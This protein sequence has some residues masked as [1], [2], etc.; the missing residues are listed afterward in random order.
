MSR[1]FLH[2]DRLTI[3]RMPGIAPGFTIDA[4]DG[5][6]LVIGPNES[7]K[8]SLVRAFRL[9]LWPNESAPT[10]FGADAVF[11]DGDGP[12]RAVRQGRSAEPWSRDGAVVAPPSLPPGHLAACYRLGLLDLHR[13]QPGEVEK[14]LAAAIRR[15][16]AGGF[17]IDPVRDLFADEAHRLKLGRGKYQEAAEQLR[18]LE[19][20]Q[21]AL[22]AEE[23]GL[24]K[25]EIARDAAEAALR[26]QR[27]LEAALAWRGLDRR[28]QALQARLAE[29]P[30]GMER[31][32][33]DDDT[34]LAKVDASI[35]RLTEGVAALEERIAARLRLIADLRLAGD[36][37][38][39][40]EL[41]AAATAASQEQARA[42]A[43]VAEATAAVQ[44]ARTGL[45]PE[46][47]AG[48][49]D[50]ADAEAVRQLVRRH[51]DLTARLA[52]VAGWDAAL[53]AFT[54]T[55]TSATGLREETADTAGRSRGI[56]TA[57]APWLG[58]A[59]LVAG[60]ALAA[61]DRIN[62]GL[63]AGAVGVLLSILGAITWRRQAAAARQLGAAEG[64][65]DARQALAE[66][67]TLRRDEAERQAGQ[68][69]AARRELLTRHGRDPERDD[70]DL[71]H[72][73]D[74][75]IRWRAAAAE[76]AVAE[77]RRDHDSA[78]AT[79]ACR[80]AAARLAE[81]GEPAE[82]NLA[83]VTAGGIRVQERQRRCGELEA[84][85]VEDRTQQKNLAVESAA[86]REARRTL[87]VRLGLDA[88]ADTPDEV[89]TEVDRRVATLAQWQEL[90][91]ERDEVQAEHQ[92][93]FASLDTGEDRALLN[94]EDERLESAIAAGREQ[95]AQ[96]DELL[97]AI[98]ALRERIRSARG[99]RDLEDAQAAL[100]SQADRIGELFDSHR[101]GLAGHLLLD[102]IAA[103]YEE[104]TRPPV[105]EELNR[106]LAAFTG[107]R[108]HL[109]VE[110]TAA[111][112]GFVAIGDDGD[113]RDLTRL[114]DG[115]RAQLLLAARLAFLNRS[116]DGTGLPLF[117]DE[118]LTAS[119]PE[120]FGA[121]AVALGT[122]A[123]D[124]GR[125]VFYLTSNPGDVGAWRTALDA[126]GLPPAHVIDLAAVRALGGAA[127]AAQLAPAAGA[128][129]PSPEGL[130]GPAYA[131]LLLVPALDPRRESDG[132]HM[133]Y[134]CREDTTLLHRLLCAGVR[135]LG[136]WRRSGAGLTAA[137]HFTPA[138]SAALANRAAVADAFL[139]SWRIGRGAPLTPEDLDAS[140]A[141]SDVFRGPARELLD[142]TGPNAAA[143]LAR[144]QDGALPRFS[145][146]KKEALQDYLERCGHLD[147]RAVLT[148]EELVAQV[149][150]VSSSALSAADVRRLVLDLVA[151]TAR[152]DG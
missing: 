82:P 75:V 42:D 73:W 79:A 45:D 29:L 107:N 12:L 129:I 142:Q 62:L 126:A 147:D 89:Q 25:L 135:T 145:A 18:S 26:A 52:A 120:R 17:D 124:T 118:A 94:W 132:M 144:V 87:L 11:H 104:D 53:G 35:T 146:S 13:A 143:F 114:S 96:R 47:A 108:Y 48:P 21:E 92:R 130:D 141:F 68:A 84:A 88:G 7:G 2:L 28:L 117:L 71:A 57:A 16:M 91:G 32:R 133:Y 85:L 66:L 140:E 65:R 127:T 55:A 4:R 61:T 81:L 148:P 115:T 1:N 15:Q 67:M 43:A 113:R 97:G 41:I 131:R 37:A 20:Q 123:R 54:G 36:P 10:P 50:P 27:R 49:V 110:Q 151:A 44:Q 121:I 19:R 72:E 106:L 101:L 90:A 105:L 6:N 59:A 23:Q 70:A 60:V 33:D 30:D 5:V 39:L 150:T 22:A 31:V 112:P 64:S 69:A 51:A 58:I 8:S 86:A 152:S 100:D 76:L 38:G 74:L 149:L 139:E 119:D 111:G 80:A 122:I 24:A 136:Q 99:R 128:E 40:T 116:E 95:A 63:G 56:A 83:A 78:A 138:E 102:D 103:E 3:D 134:L 34:T 9:L 109:R 93:V 77:A 137:G 98:S 14:D 46:V 125:Q